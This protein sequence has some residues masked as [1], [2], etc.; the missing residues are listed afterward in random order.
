MNEDA[1]RYD[2]THGDEDD[3]DYIPEWNEDY[4]YLETEPC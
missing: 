4:F 2:H 1:G 3:Y